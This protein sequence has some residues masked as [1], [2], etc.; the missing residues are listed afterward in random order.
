VLLPFPDKP[1][2][3]RGPFDV[4]GMSDTSFTLAWQPPETDGGS[5]ILVYIVERREV[6]KKA[7]QKVCDCCILTSRLKTTAK[8]YSYNLVKM[9]MQIEMN[10]HY[11]LSKYKTLKTS[12]R[13]KEQL[14]YSVFLL[15]LY[16]STKL[17]ICFGNIENIVC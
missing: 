9:L 13:N 11:R 15:S 16:G 7:W 3:P 4:S 1:S 12:I 8:I 2:P 17:K 5:P 6:N 10:S 14:N